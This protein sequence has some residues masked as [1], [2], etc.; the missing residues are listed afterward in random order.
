[1]VA[2]NSVTNLKGGRALGK[3]SWLIWNRGVWRGILYTLFHNPSPAEPAVHRVLALAVSIPMFAAFAA[4]AV[5][6]ETRM[7]GVSQAGAEFGKG[8]GGFNKAYTYPGATQLDYC[9]KKGLRVIRLP[10]KWERMQHQLMAP[11]DPAELARMDGVVKLARE[12]D[13]KLIL[14]M[15]NYARYDGKLIGTAGVPNTAYADV[16]R[17]LAGHYRGEQAI[18]AYGIMN[19]PHGTKGLWPAAAQACVDAIRAVDADH[20]ILACGG[21]WSGAHSW[22]QING[23]FLLKDPA[24]RLVYE[25]HQYFDRN[26]S[27]SYRKSYDEEGAY[28]TVGADRLQP[29]ITWLKK[30]NVQGFIG[31]FGVPDNDPRWLVVLDH[32]LAEMKKHQLGGTYWAAGP[33]WG[34]Y[35][36]CLEPRDGQ[37]R[38]QMA[39][40]EQYLGVGTGEKPWVEAAKGAEAAARKAR[41]ADAKLGKRLHDFGARKESYHYSNKGSE[42]TSE[43]AEDNGRKVRKISYKHIGEPAWIGLGVYFGALNCKDR[44]AFSLDLRAATPCRLEIKAYTPT[45]ERYSATFAIGTEWQTLVIPFVKL[46]ADG[47]GYAAAKPIQKI[48]FQPSTSRAGSALYLGTLRLSPMP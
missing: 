48:E 13:L 45:G 36:L 22:P 11:L 9:Q 37:D 35:P 16:W 7:L 25:A 21:G 24:G 44:A 8:R 1:V 27:G 33:W 15:H 10:F 6:P 38:P 23:T 42:F 31:E 39:V 3:Q 47:K 30:H 40:I 18:F 46:M 34:K 20:T 4:A 17:K 26:N 19:E 5:A 29:F 28:P 2:G 43:A 14:D 41:E 32:T 12:R